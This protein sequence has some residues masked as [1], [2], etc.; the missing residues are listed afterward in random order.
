MK[1]K[2]EIQTET[3]NEV[4]ETAIHDAEPSEEIKA[5]AESPETVKAEP[6]RTGNV[7]YIG[8]TIR[9]TIQKGTT[10]AGGV[11]PSKVNAVLDEF[12]AGKMLFVPV[13]ELTEA[14]KNLNT[15]NSALANISDRMAR[16]YS[17]R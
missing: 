17:K 9:N 7:M 4:A 12:P 5:E 14:V 11:Y 13:E 1:K 16:E 15:K 3:V 6:E 2:Q 8:P 10:F